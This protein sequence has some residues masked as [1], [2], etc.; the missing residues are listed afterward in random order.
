MQSD[1][2]TMLLGFRSC[3]EKTLSKM[4]FRKGWLAG[5]RAGRADREGRETHPVNDAGRVQV[6]D[7]AKHLV[8]Q[9]GHALVVQVHLDHLTQIRVH[10]FHDEVHVLELLEGLLRR[11]GIQQSDDLERDNSDSLSLSLARRT[12]GH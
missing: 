6:F 11:E 9:V 5:W 10:Q 3:E 7:A 12:G 4:R 8:E 2:T 1:F